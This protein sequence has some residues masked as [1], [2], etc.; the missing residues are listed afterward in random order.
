MSAHEVVIPVIGSRIH[1]DH[2]YALYSAIKQALNVKDD[3]WSD[4]LLRQVNGRE[5]SDH[6]LELTTTSH[7]VLRTTSY[8]KARKLQRLA[9]RSVSLLKEKTRVNITFGRPTTL[10]VEPHPDF[11]FR[12]IT[13][14][15]KT[16]LRGNKALFRAKI[17]RRLADA[18]INYD[19][20][21]I[22][23]WKWILCHNLIGGYEVRIYGVDSESSIRLQSECIFAKTS[24]GAGF[25]ERI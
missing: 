1:K 4:V 16:G 22:H 11:K 6:M 13:I 7:C 25:A 18:G 3:F 20:L 2:G 21:D 24:M 19:R 5:V 8:Q 12:I 15:S 9:H 17:E 23:V 14:K 10:I